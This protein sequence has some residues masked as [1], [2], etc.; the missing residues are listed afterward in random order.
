MHLEFWIDICYL[1]K[2]TSS[3]EDAETPATKQKGGGREG[4]A[5]N[6]TN[7]QVATKT[8]N[9]SKMLTP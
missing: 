8:T 5:Y 3:Q 7:I 6:R 4:E 9:W 2:F 1:H